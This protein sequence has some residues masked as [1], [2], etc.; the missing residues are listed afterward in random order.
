MTN[1]DLKKARAIYR[2]CLVASNGFED[3]YGG[4]CDISLDEDRFRARMAAELPHIRLREVSPEEFVRIAR[5]S[6]DK[7]RLD[8][9][10]AFPAYLED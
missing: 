5:M 3:E 2:D 4:G 1:E 8:G 9:D 6:H 10:D 7:D